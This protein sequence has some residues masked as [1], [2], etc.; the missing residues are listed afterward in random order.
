MFFLLANLTKSSHDIYP[1]ALGLQAISKKA[2][3]AV[4]FVF[5]SSKIGRPSSRD[6]R[7]H[8]EIY[9]PK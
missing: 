1:A 2:K 8:G 6:K 9:I 5:Y 4:Q 3:H 7:Y